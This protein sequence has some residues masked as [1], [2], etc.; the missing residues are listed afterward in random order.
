MKKDPV[1]RPG[2]IGSS[3]LG[4]TAGFGTLHLRRLPDFTGP[5]PQSL[6]IRYSILRIYYTTKASFCQ[7]IYVKW[8]TGVYTLE[9]L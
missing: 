2:R 3:S 4:N 7:S 9:Q 6:L 5:V 1:K 8:E